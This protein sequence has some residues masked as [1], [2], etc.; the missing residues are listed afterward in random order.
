MTVLRSATSNDNEVNV[1]KF[2]AIIC[3]GYIRECFL[4]KYDGIS[5]ASFV[6][7]EYVANE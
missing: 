2:F 6:V 5:K 7:R 1:S 3:A 4:D